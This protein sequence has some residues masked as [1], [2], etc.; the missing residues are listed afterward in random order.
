MGRLFWKF[1]LAFWAALMLTLVTMIVAAWLMRL[2]NDNSKNS[3]EADKLNTLLDSASSLLAQGE[4]RATGLVLDNWRRHQLRPTI[5]LLSQNAVRPPAGFDAE[6]TRE[7]WQRAQRGDDFTRF[8]KL[9][10]G[11]RFA[12]VV[13]PAELDVLL[14]DA[15][16]KG[17]PPLL[18]FIVVSTVVSLFISALLAWYFSKPIR[19]LSW[20]L[21]KVAEGRLETRVGGRMGRRRDEIAGLGHDF[22][23]MAQRLQELVNSRRRL[24]HDVSHEL[25][26]PLARL[27]AAIGLARQRPDPERAMAMLERIEREAQRLDT[28]VGEILTLARLTDSEVQASAEPVDLVEMVAAIAEDAQ[29]EARAQGREVSLAAHGEFIAEVNAELLF[30]AFENVIRNA[31][32]FTAAG[33]AVEIA[34][35]TTP[36]GLQVMVSDRGPGVAEADM[37]RIFEPFRRLDEREGVPGFGLGLAIARRAI[38]S[39]GGTISASARPGGGLCMCMQLPR[40]PAVA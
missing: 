21:H 20:A 26:S 23:R 17:A 40:K 35:E 29:F 7:A 38:E 10:D 16:P 18:L 13:P 5:T 14:D 1:F 30:R 36:E 9:D 37:R 22:D 39:H 2:F 4:V 32:K 27:Q 19:S 24:L 8:I 12:L 31:L 33:S 15:R 34:V 11:R 3:Y 6:Q 28:L 25:R